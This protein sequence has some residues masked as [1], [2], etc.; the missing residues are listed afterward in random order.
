MYFLRMEEGK[1][2]SII[3]KSAL[4]G[5]FIVLVGLI[6]SLGAPSVGATA[7]VGVGVPA[8]GWVYYPPPPPYVVYPPYLY[9]GGF[10][11]GATFGPFYHRHWHH[12]R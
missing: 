9:P 10:F 6:G 4:L 12:W 11:I 1:V 2:M 7:F 5:A 8:V 3:R